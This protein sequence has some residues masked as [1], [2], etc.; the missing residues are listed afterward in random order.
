MIDCLFEASH[1]VISLF[2]QTTSF[3]SDSFNLSR[4]FPQLAAPTTIL[5]LLSGLLQFLCSLIHSQI[6]FIHAFWL[7]PS[8]SFSISSKLLILK[9]WMKWNEI[10][11]QKAEV[12]W[13]NEF[14]MKNDEWMKAR[15]AS[16]E[17]FV[18]EAAFRP[19]N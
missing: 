18:V 14:R 4:H 2:N 13:R 17:W 12:S 11:R 7:Q 19:V 3:H 9:V 10:R 15:P 5:S 16:H 1:S 8:I 6:N